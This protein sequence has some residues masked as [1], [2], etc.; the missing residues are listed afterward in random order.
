MAAVGA[1][2][3]LRAAA[4]S[5][6]R[7]RTRGSPTAQMARQRTGRFSVVVLAPPESPVAAQADATLRAVG[8]ADVHYAT[9]PADLMR[10]IPIPAEIG[11][12]VICRSPHESSVVQLVAQLRQRGWRRLIVACADGDESAVRTAIAA[13]V[14]GFIKRPDAAERPSAIATAPAVAA[15]GITDLSVREVEVLQAVAD[16]HTNN[17]IGELLGLSGL[18]VKSHLA[19][20]GRKAGTGDRA[21]MVARAMRSGLL[22]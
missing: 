6:P 22:V 19:R 17:E 14:R 3:A 5:A 7:Q 4:S 8:A 11:V 1:A 21:E 20:I 15:P 9:S 12:G 13:K 10:K 18:T 2:E 16:G